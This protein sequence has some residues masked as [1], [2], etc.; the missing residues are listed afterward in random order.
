MKE[1]L[2]LVDEVA[3]FLRVSRPRL[4][5]W[6]RMGK[7]PGIKIAGTWRIPES[8]LNQLLAP[9]ANGA[10]DVQSIARATP[11]AAVVEGSNS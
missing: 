9:A 11:T 5:R 8:A 2:L 6:L 10:A 1:K 3:G 4:Y 7:L